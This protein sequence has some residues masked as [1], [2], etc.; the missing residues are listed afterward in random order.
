MASVSLFGDSNM[1]TVTSRENEDELN[2][3][4]NIKERWMVATRLLKSVRIDKRF[5]DL[6][7]AS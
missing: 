1:A 5:E 3:H 7:V 4:I 6:H 2:C